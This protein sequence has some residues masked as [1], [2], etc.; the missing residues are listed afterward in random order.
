MAF[1]VE[2]LER[3][4][5][6]QAPDELRD[7][8]VFQQIVVRHFLEQLVGVLLTRRDRLLGGPEA[9]ALAMTSR[10]GGR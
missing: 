1:L 7:E 9:D 4:D 5:H 6:R 3:H 10:A 2:R 8:A